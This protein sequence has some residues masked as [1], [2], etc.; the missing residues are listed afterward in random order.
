[1]ETNTAESTGE[2]HGRID[3]SALLGKIGTPGGVDIIFA[4]PFRVAERI[5]EL[6]LVAL[7]AYLANGRRAYD[8]VVIVTSPLFSDSADALRK[9]VSAAMHRFRGTHLDDAE[10]AALERRLLVQQTS[11][12]ETRSVVELLRGVPRG[13][14]AIVIDSTAYREPGLKLAATTIGRIRVVEDMWVPHLYSLS[15]ECV[16]VALAT[17]GCV[18][19]DCEQ[20]GPTRTSNLELL[21]S[22]DS[23]ALLTAVNDQ[24]PDEQS[25]Q[26]SQ[27]WIGYVKMGR[28]DLALKLIEALPETV[29]E[30]KI[31]FKVQALHMGGDGVAATALLKSELDE[32]NQF[33]PVFRVRAANIAEDAGSPDLARSLLDNTVASLSTEEWLEEALVLSRRLSMTDVQKECEDRLASLFPNS[34]GLRDHYYVMLLQACQDLAHGIVAQTLRGTPQ[35]V[36]C[37][38]GLLAA[39]SATEH[40]DYKAVLLHVKEHSPDFFAAAQL[41]CAHHAKEIGRIGQAMAL[42]KPAEIPGDF[43]RHASRILLWGIELTLLGKRD[44][45]I[46]DNTVGA[47]ITEVL[48]YLGRHPSDTPTRARFARVMSVQIAGTEGIALLARAVLSLVRKDQQVHDKLVDVNND[49][50]DDQFKTFFEA[51][52]SW[53]EA[54]E[55]LE[56][57]H[58]QLPG[59]LMVPS[60]DAL[61]DR[62]VDMIYLVSRMHDAEEDLRFLQQLVTVA[63]ATAPHTSSPEDDLLVLRVAATKYANTGRPQTARDYA[64][65]G[66]TITHE[67]PLRRRLA[68]FGFADVYQ[69][70]RNAINALIGMGCALTCQA[71]VT[72]QQAFYETYG[73]IRLLRDLG[74][75]E[76]AE[77]LLPTC[78]ALVTKLG[79]QESMTP[80]IQTIRL[81]LRFRVVGPGTDTGVLKVLADDVMANLRDVL[82]HHD[83]AMPAATMA[84]QLFQLCDDAGVAVDIEARALLDRAADALGTTSGLLMRLSGNAAPTAAEVF[85]WLERFEAARYS[86]DVGYDIHVLARS[87]RRLLTTTQAESDPVVAMFAAELTTDHGVNL[88][89]QEQESRE[90]PAWLP[91]AME[92]PAEHARAISRRGLVV[93]VLA[94]NDDERLVRVSAQGGELQPVV[95]EDEQVFSQARLAEWSKTFPYAYGFPTDDPNLFYS[96]TLGLGLTQQTAERSVIV[97]DIELQRLSANLLV[98]ENELLGVRTATAVA[99]SLA[100]LHA[101]LEVRR[102]EHKPPVAWISTATEDG[103][104]GTLEMLASRLEEPLRNYG[105]PLETTAN[106]PPALEGAELAIVAAHGSVGAEG[107]YFQVVADE[108]DFRMNQIDLANALA[109]AGV[110]ILFVCSGGRFDQHPVA[111]TAVALPKEL[112]DRGCSAVVGS[113][114]PLDSSVPAHWLPAFLD[115]WYGDIPLIDATY[116]ANKAVEKTLGNSPAKWLAMTVYG[117]PLATR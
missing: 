21:K 48:A 110:V 97:L 90:R 1:M 75:V 11:S 93:S 29:A 109:N 85:E 64:E 67:D 42:A 111:S 34:I 96:S 117:N 115:A 113:P 45:E 102:T 58:V 68:W 74:M 66:L 88:P 77:I 40:L 99:P 30:H 27:R 28:T 35:F 16:D 95:V 69:R 76:L 54:N 104:L 46:D 51:A 55:P 23:C 4:G 91:S 8:C 94:M 86:E 6:A 25:L 61:F 31:A 114:W 106:M 82:D 60:A 78:E 49:A 37:G 72:N 101:A 2:W 92:Q 50:T 9:H 83:E 87:A 20:Y 7:T 62:L 26:S 22:V 14:L 56:M 105:I 44:P 71:S 15:R 53:C 103:S 43:A 32:G 63:A 57:G 80:R 17:Q 52:L 98:V 5:S 13:S 107:R 108:D 18:I 12:L 84:A 70:S 47:A 116:Q 89:D 41:A 79:L 100:W 112:L 19:L 10:L 39:L 36:A 65:L 33:D 81:S 73:M 24:N 59:E 3:W 38:E